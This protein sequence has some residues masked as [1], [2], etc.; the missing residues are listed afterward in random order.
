MKDLLNRGAN[1]AGALE[2]AGRSAL[3]AAGENGHLPIVRLLLDRKAPID[4]VDDD[5]G[6]TALHVAAMSGFPDIVRLLAL[7]GASLDQPSES[8]DT[9]LTIAAYKNRLGSVRALIGAR[10]NIAARGDQD[11]TAYEWAV[12]Q[13]N[14]EVAAFLQKVEQQTGEASSLDSKLLAR[15]ARTPPSEMTATDLG[16]YVRLRAK[17]L[18]LEEHPQISS[19]IT[20]AEYDGE[21]L[22][23]ADSKALRRD[24]CGGDGVRLSRL[25]RAVEVLRS[26]NESRLKSRHDSE[27]KL[28]LSGK[29][30]PEWYSAAKNGYTKKVTQL[31][32]GGADIDERGGYKGR[33]ALHEATWNHQTTMV[34]LLIDLGAN[35]N[36]SDDHGNT[37]LHFAAFN[38]NRDI[39]DLLIGAKANLHATNM[40]GKTALMK[41]HNRGRI[42]NVTQLV[43][44][45]RKSASSD[46]P[47]VSATRPKTQKQLPV[48]T[49][50]RNPS[51]ECLPN[52]HSERGRHHPWPKSWQGR[53]CRRFSR[54]RERS[55]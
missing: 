12:A 17:V 4:A 6:R 3:H 51:L 11:K 9:A 46:G 32:N 1:P 27:R 28:A 50:P 48:L 38:G 19:A 30:G 55:T 20:S 43:E 26:E 8:G 7:R 45:E 14:K 13:E 29:N 10:A 15:L 25:L 31:F 34:Q 5:D 24:L 53:F 41:A 22:L 37:P 23:R 39:T 35:V 44:A 47:S 42:G 54:R 33:T 2:S 18:G 52:T 21:I 49:Q 40:Y 36:Q 16:N